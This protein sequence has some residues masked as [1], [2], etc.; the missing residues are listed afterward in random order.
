MNYEYNGD[1]IRVTYEK[2]ITIGG[3]CRLHGSY[4]YAGV[5][6]G[7]VEIQ[8]TIADVEYDNAPSSIQ[9]WIDAICPEGIYDPNEE[10]DSDT[11]FMLD[12]CL[13]APWV[14]AE[15]M[16]T[17]ELVYMPLLEFIQHSSIA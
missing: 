6:E 17:G 7:L 13:N 14:V 11:Q 10:Y 12:E 9:A 15:H 3:V 1:E 16:I 8:D 2:C 5:P 4:A